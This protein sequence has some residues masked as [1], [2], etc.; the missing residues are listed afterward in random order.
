MKF[1]LS[2]LPETFIN[3]LQVRKAL[4]TLNPI[5]I[6]SLELCITPS[7]RKIFEQRRG[8]SSTSSRSTIKNSRLPIMHR[9]L[10]AGPRRGKPSFI[11]CFDSKTQV[12]ALGF[13]TQFPR[14]RTVP[15]LWKVRIG[16]DFT[17]FEYVLVIFETVNFLMMRSR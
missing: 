5:L 10:A 17:T 1:A 11:S 13:V 12:P 15:H 16:K 3:M 14:G 4:A 7:Y 2:A 6:P 8:E 9:H